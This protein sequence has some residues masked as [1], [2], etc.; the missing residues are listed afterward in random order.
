M[1]HYSNI[2]TIILRTN[3]NLF[4]FCLITHTGIFFDKF[5]HIKLLTVYDLR[6]RYTC[7]HLILIC[8]YL[9]NLASHFKPGALCCFHMWY[10]DYKNKVIV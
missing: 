1:L 4:Y 2:I 9:M 6:D 7:V 5:L 10:E 3:N 8:S